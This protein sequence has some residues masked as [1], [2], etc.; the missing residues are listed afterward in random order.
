MRD[1]SLGRTRTC[2]P[3]WPP[4]VCRIRHIGPF[5]GMLR[6]ILAAVRS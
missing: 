1:L 4:Q 3:E 2:I 6:E 5:P